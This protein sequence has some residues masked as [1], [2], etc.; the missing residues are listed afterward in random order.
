MVHDV[1]TVYLALRARILSGALAPDTLLDA[2][3]LERSFGISDKRV[4]QVLSSLAGDGFLN[5]SRMTYSVTTLT[6][7]EVEEWLQIFCALIELGA[8]RLVLDGDPKGEHLGSI[9]KKEAA[10]L[11]AVDERFYLWMLELFCTLL[12]GQHAKLT[13][14]AS[15]LVPPMFFRLLGLAEI[16]TAGGAGLRGMANQIIE[17]AR[18]GRNA[19][20][21]SDACRSHF[22]AV[23]VALHAQLDHR[24]AGTGPDLLGSFE[25]TVERRI[26]GHINYLR[27]P[28]A[29][30]P[31]FPRLRASQ[32][33]VVKGFLPD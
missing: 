20:M 24:N 30:K 6:H 1:D 2:T 18:A 27:T 26:N 12:G 4:R 32:V 3:E 17:A 5:R 22:E 11:P 16:E 23:S 21:A 29:P 33:A 14:F 19:R 15:Q 9:L 8:A 25:R 10:S 13:A 7:A 31:L 28:S